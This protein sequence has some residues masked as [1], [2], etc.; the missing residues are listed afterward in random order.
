MRCELPS[1]SDDGFSDNL[2]GN[3]G[4]RLKAGSRPEAKPAATNPVQNTTAV[5]VMNLAGNVSWIVPHG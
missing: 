2:F 4:L 5:A 3:L 1:P